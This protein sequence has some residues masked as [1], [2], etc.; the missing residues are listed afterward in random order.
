MDRS[1]NAV[2][3]ASDGVKGIHE[4]AEGYQDDAESACQRVDDRRE[5]RGRE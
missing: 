2:Y 3:R 1:I 5:M 4:A